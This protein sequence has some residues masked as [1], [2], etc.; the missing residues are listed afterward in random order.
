[1][2]VA[3][4]GLLAAGTSL[5]VRGARAHPDMSVDLPA[6][7]PLSRTEA[8]AVTRSI[9]VQTTGYGLLGA[10]VGAGVVAITSAAG[11]GRRA[12]IAEAS[13]GAALS[14]AG[15]IGLPSTA[16]SY[17]TVAPIDAT[18]ADAERRRVRDH[19][20][21]ASL[22]AGLAL[23]SGALLALIV[24]TVM[25]NRANRGPLSTLRPAL[26]AS[27]HAGGLGLLGRF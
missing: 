8:D 22:G 7:R 10:G 24:R 6:D 21:G 20:F 25:T 18:L 4:V 3:G 17:A 14:I 11:A 19:V 16:A 23:T 12:L 15:A 26:Q 27:P 9:G 2:A 13:V 5:T 1:M